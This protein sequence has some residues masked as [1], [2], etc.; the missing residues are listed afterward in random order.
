M[1]AEGIA[2]ERATRPN[3][4]LIMTDQHRV[5]LT[6]RTGCSVDTMPRLDALARQGT[7]FDRAYTSYPACVPAR[8]SLLTGRFPTAHRVRQNSNAEHAFYQADL[9]DVLRAQGFQLHFAGKPHMHPGPDDFDSY[10]G[11]YWH[12][13]GP[14]HTDDHRR[15]D[16]WLTDLDHGVAD[17]PTPFAVEDQLPYRIATDAIAAVDDS[18]RD[19]PAFWWVSFPEPHNPYQ[20]P[21]PY[22]SL[23]PEQDVPAR[24][25]GPE[26]IDAKGGNYRWLRELVEHKRPGYDDEWRRY[27][28]NYLGM[29]RLIDDQIGRLLDHLEDRHLDT[30]VIFVSDHG[31]YFADYGL[32]RKGA[33]MSDALMRIPF[34]ISGPGILPG[35]TRQELVSMVDLMPTVCE[36]IGAEIPPGVQGRGLLPLLSGEP[37]PADEFDSVIGELGYGGVPY[38]LDDHPELH[39]PY[40]GRT[41]DE[42]NSVTQSGGSRMLRRGDHKLIMDLNG[43][44]ELYDLARDPGELINL[45]D[46]PAHRA[47]RDQLSADLIR[48]MIRIADDLPTGNYAPKAAPHNWRWAQ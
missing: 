21:E 22:F 6:R 46:D 11:P 12:T 33:G 1:A 20:V 17:V 34:Q 4:L 30:V 15:F 25:A 27:R 32:Q 3:I 43:S 13:S 5:G 29:L 2:N 14:Q 41:F 9:L 26:V 28:A 36:L 24:I 19:Q 48:W 39:F 42:L 38:A 23:V 18:R 7:A 45:F 40:Q 16:N 10:A 47:T 8:T 31:D 44:G 35:Q 37:T